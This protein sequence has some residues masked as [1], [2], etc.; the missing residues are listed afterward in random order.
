[1]MTFDDASSERK[2]TMDAPCDGIHVQKD[3]V[4][5]RG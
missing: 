4:I 1:M 3:V 5:S 2:L